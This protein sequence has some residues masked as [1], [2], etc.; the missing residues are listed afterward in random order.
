MQFLDKMADRWNCSLFHY[1]NHGAA[2]GR[3][4][5]GLQ[6]EPHKKSDV[7]TFLDQLGYEFWDETEN[8]A[9]QTFLG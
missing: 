3:V 7:I 5:M 4:M 2:F 9:Y 1:R 6:V 8:D